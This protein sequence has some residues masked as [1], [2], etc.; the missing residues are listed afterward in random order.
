M[1]PILLLL[2]LICTSQIYGQGKSYDYCYQNKKSICVYS[3]ADKQ[4]QVIVKEGGTDPC[5]SPDGKK[6]A[7]TINSKGDT[8]T[9]GIIDLNSKQKI[10]LKT[11]SRNCF[12]P[13]WSPDGKYIAYSV[14]K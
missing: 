7:Y 2:L 1:K 8:R 4:E 3:I 5:I 9:V 6:V 10:T 11:N 14:F 13:V 12:G